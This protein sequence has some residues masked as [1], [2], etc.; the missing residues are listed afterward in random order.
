VNQ[1]IYSTSVNRWRNY[2]KHLDPLRAALAE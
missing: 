1:P 2:D